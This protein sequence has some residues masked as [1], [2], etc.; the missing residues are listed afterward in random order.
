VDPRVPFVSSVSGRVE[1]HAEAARRLLA[2]QVTSAVRWTDV[3][4]TLGDLGITDAV[5]VGAGNILTQLGKRAES[6]IRFHSF[7]EVLHAGV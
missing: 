1:A 4:R 5:E 2:T 3:L 7:E 6:R